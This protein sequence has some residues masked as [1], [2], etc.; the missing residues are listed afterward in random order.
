MNFD[1]VIVPDDEVNVQSRN[2]TKKN[3]DDAIVGYLGFGNLYVN[4]IKFYR[5]A[6]CF[7]RI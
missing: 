5:H 1:Y 6:T 3:W 7:N 2:E 4:F